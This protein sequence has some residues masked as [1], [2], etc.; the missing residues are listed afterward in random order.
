MFE[1]TEITIHSFN[2][3][4]CRFDIRSFVKSRTY[5][6]ICPRSYFAKDGSTK[7]E[8]AK[9]LEKVNDCC[10]R[11]IGTHNFHN[12][13]KNLK[14]KDPKARR[15]I[16][17]FS[18]IEIDDKWFKFVIKG[19]SFVYHQ[20]RKIIGSILQ[21]FMSEYEASFIDNTFFNN[22]FYVPLAPP[23]GLYLRTLTFQSYNRKTDIPE[24]I[25]FDKCNESAQ[26][27]EKLINEH[28]YQID[29][30][31]WDEWYELVKE[32]VVPKFEE[33]EEEGANDDD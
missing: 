10:A 3:V 24:K 14:C 26:K 27:V 28:I 7:Q 19:Q 5:C 29:Q 30:K 2:K 32:G 16:L 13:S 23:F 17:E 31:S 18:C 1:N 20:I 21:V 25:D 8:I 15:Y 9:A 11:F 12:Y 33:D 22:Q 6:Y 4:S